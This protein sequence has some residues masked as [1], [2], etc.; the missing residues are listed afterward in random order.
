M[1]YHVQQV[2]VSI[3]HICSDSHTNLLIVDTAVAQQEVWP[4][5]FAA[6]LHIQHNI[7]R[8]TQSVQQD[9]RVF[10]MKRCFTFV[11]Q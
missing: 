5:V 1:S 6:R 7:L 10:H 9:H 8:Q 2:C 11:L 4:T 3:L